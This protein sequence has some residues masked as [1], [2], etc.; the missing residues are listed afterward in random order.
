VA[1]YRFDAQT[2]QLISQRTVGS[3][4]C[5]VQA[6]LTGWPGGRLWMSVGSV[7]QLIR[8]V[9]W[10]VLHTVRVPAGQVESLSVSPDRRRLY[11][12]IDH[13][14]AAGGGQLQER[15]LPGWRLVHTATISR[16][17]NV[18]QISAANGALWVTAGGGTT[19]EVQ[20]FT[21]DLAH[22]RLA[23]GAG[24]LARGQEE[25]HFFTFEYVAA[26]VL[27]GVSWLTASNALACLNP[28][29]GRVLAEQ[30]GDNTPIV[31]TDPVAVG[32]NIYGLG[33]DGLVEMR[34]PAACRP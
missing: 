7:V 3:G 31:S 8:P 12:A 9:P 26:T 32:G 34:P 10:A 23:L 11:L 16:L 24:E 14:G 1:L 28:E 22:V 27:G 15:T 20:L 2:L 21:A 18:G 4:G 5:C 29:S 13:A 6:T 33:H 30:P 25:R 17:L 19:A